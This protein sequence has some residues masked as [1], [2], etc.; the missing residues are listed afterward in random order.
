MHLR[1]VDFCA[2]TLAAI[3]MLHI[4]CSELLTHSPRTSSWSEGLTSICWALDACGR[5]VYLGWSGDNFCYC[6]TKAGGGF[7]ALPSGA[8]KITSGVLKCRQPL[9][10]SGGVFCAC[11]RGSGEWICCP[12]KPV[13]VDI[14]LQGKRSIARMPWLLALVHCQ[15]DD[16]QCSGR[17]ASPTSLLYL[18]VLV[19]QK[20]AVGLVG[21]ALLFDVRHSGHVHLA[22]AF[23]V[24]CCP[25]GKDALYDSWHPLQSTQKGPHI[26]GAKCAPT[27][28]GSD[29]PAGRRRFRSLSLA[30]DFSWRMD[31]ATRKKEAPICLCPSF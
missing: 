2:E 24:T 4:T 7:R 15:S 6:M 25:T 20:P 19:V 31:A 22:G 12:W 21:N 1:L 30:R 17:Y 23:F 11:A 27:G 9:L 18:P 13:S 26:T 8:A 29:F 14:S 5:S 10:S 16:P 28:L 3:H